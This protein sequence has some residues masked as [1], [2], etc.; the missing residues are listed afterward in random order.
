MRPFFFLVSL[1]YFVALE[2]EVDTHEEA[3]K[4]D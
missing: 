1:T 4:E 2:L 3:E